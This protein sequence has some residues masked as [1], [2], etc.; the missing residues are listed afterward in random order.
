[1]RRWGCIFP[2][3]ARPPYKNAKKIHENARAIPADRLVSE[4]DS[5]YLTPEPFRG[6]FPNEPEKVKYVV[7]NLARLREEKRRSWRNAFSPTRSVC[8]PD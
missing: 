8:S 6:S 7:E 2:W 1:M 4:T 5:P 3:A